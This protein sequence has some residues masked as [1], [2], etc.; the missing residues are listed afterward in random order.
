MLIAYFQIKADGKA[1]NQD[2]LFDGTSVRHVALHHTKTVP[3]PAM[4]FCVA[5]A[6]GVSSS[7]KSHLASRFW[8]NA[9]ASTPAVAVGTRAFFDEYFDKFCNH[10]APTALGSATTIAG[11]VIDETG[12]CLIF[13]VGDSSVFVIDDGVW[14]KL[15]HDHTILNELLHDDIKDGVEYAKMYGGLAECL[16]ADPNE[17]DFKIHHATHTLTQGQTLLICTDGL[18]DEFSMDELTLMWHSQS[19]LTDRLAIMLHNLKKRRGRD[20]C[21]VVAVEI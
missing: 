8:L 18:T 7:P 13:N 9:I 16:I 2:A 10:I 20:D 4:P 3:T 19:T 6:D 5:V 12:A 15:S 1:V 21:S 17:Y 11:A 14:H